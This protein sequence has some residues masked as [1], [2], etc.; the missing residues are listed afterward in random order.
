[1]IVKDGQPVVERLFADGLRLRPTICRMWVE[2]PG[3]EQVEVR[4]EHDWQVV[5]REGSPLGSA[6]ELTI[7]VLNLPGLFQKFAVGAHNYPQR[8]DLKGFSCGLP[9]GDLGYFLRLEDSGELHRILMLGV[10]GAF[11]F[12]QDEMVFTVHK[13]ADRVYGSGRG[14]LLGKEA[15]WVGTT[16]EDAQTTTI[17]WKAL[18]GGA[19]T[20]DKCAPSLVEPRFARLQDL[21]MPPDW[22]EE[23]LADGVILKAREEPLG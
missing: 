9:M 20:Q 22:V 14:P 3:G 17:S 23:A 2:H 7:E 4:A 13:L 16:D 5:G 11:E 1:M 15:A 12:T 21:E 6:K 10:S 8:D 19:D 18:E